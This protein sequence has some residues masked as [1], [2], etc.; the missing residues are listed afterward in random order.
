VLSPNRAAD[1]SNTYQLPSGQVITPTGTLTLAATDPTGATGIIN[2]GPAQP[3][4]I[5]L[6]L[7]NTVNSGNLVYQIDPVANGG[8]FGNFA[9]LTV[10]RSNVSAGTVTAQLLGNTTIPT[11]TLSGTTLD[12]ISHALIVTQGNLGT[13]TGQIKTGFNQGAWN[14][15][16]GILSSAAAADTTHLKAVG[17]LLNDD[18]HGNPLYGSGAPLGLLDGLNPA[19]DAVL[20]KYTYYG[21]ANLDGVV[22]GSDYSRIDNGYL[23]QLTGWS[24]G[25]F[26]YDGVIDGSDYTLI[27]NAFNSQGASLASEIAGSPLAIATAQISGPAGV[28]AVPE[29]ASLSLLGL[30]S[31]A[32][33]GRRRRKFH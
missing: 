9:G 10:E 29:P 12:V 14:G 27:D 32:L 2:V 3:S 26:N 33:L 6:A 25:D 22:D 18:G 15:T 31:V 11:L 8:T 13:I 1:L 20:V 7:D 23:N 28:A 4:S 19:V 30:G 21:D 5:S 16:T 24:N 17:V